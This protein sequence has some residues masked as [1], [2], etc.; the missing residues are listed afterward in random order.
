MTSLDLQQTTVMAFIKYKGE[1]KMKKLL[2][3]KKVYDY[4]TK[5]EAQADMK[6][7]KEKAY[8]V[9]DQY[10]AETTYVVT[11]EK[12]NMQ[13]VIAGYQQQYPVQCK[14]ALKL[15]NREMLIMR[16]LTTAEVFEATNKG[17]EFYDQEE[18]TSYQVWYDEQHEE[19]V[20]RH[21]GEGAGCFWTPIKSVQTGYEV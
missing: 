6:K 15:N 21:C 19:L 7:M 5:A 8:H 17:L 13:L 12:S 2:T 4:S 16:E 11:Y 18:Q 20:Y 3:T 1:L 10:Q 14:L 9:T